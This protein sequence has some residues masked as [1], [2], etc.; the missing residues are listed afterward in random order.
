[1][2]E[3][4]PLQL[5]QLSALTQSFNR[6]NF[7]SVASCRQNYATVHSHAVQQNRARPAVARFTTAL[8]AR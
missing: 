4:E 2:L 6:R 8:G 3:K 5:V 1:M 7:F